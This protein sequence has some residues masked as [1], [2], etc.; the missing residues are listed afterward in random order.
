MSYR[1]LVYAFKLVRLERCDFRHNTTLT[2]RNSCWQKVM[3]KLNRFHRSRLQT[4]AN[5]NQDTK[6]LHQIYSTSIIL[7]K[8]FEP[9]SNIPWLKKIIWVIGVLKIAHLLTATLS[10]DQSN[11]SPGFLNFQLTK[12]TT[13]LWIWLPHRSSNV[14]H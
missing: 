13:W 14:S 9:R 6:I 11:R 5:W 12:T 3:E 1:L 2:M 8:W 10:T 4:I 7:R